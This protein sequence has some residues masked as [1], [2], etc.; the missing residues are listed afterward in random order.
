MS[1][2]SSAL[3]SP[4]FRNLFAAH[5]VSVF[6]DGLVPVALAIGVLEQT[7]SPTLLGL[8]VATRS[9]AMVLFVLAGGVWADRLPRRSLMA[10]A[11]VVRAVTQLG[12][13]AVL[14][15]AGPIAAL[16]AL[17]FAHGAASA[18]ANPAT[19]GLVAETVTRR[20]WLWVSVLDAGVFALTATAAFVV[21][22]PAVASTTSAAA[23]R[24]R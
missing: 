24:G 20:T 2:G 18:V 23:G 22:A 8:V 3:W 17:Q 7:G 6:G 13:A 21:L 14:I 16:A 10:A 11:D 5:V 1:G 15:G 4:A 9:I 19:T 12:S